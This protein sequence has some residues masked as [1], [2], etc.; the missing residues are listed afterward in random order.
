MVCR[1]RHGWLCA[2]VP[3]TPLSRLRG[4]VAPGVA[5][6]LQLYAWA[7]SGPGSTVGLALVTAQVWSWGDSWSSGW[8]LR[9]LSDSFLPPSVR[10]TDI[11]C[12]W[13]DVIHS[14]GACFTLCGYHSECLEQSRDPQVLP[15]QNYLTT[16]AIARSTC[17]LSPPSC[18]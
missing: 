9:H 11:T 3:S 4:A 16:V 5:P 6:L 18:L 8:P 15:K 10:H 12:G 14:Q 13:G 17:L 2:G 1:H 7:T